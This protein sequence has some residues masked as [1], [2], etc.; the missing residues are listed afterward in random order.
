MQ[1]PPS[2]SPPRSVR[3]SVPALDMTTPFTPNGI[4]LVVPFDFM[5]D[6]EYWRWLPEGVPF[7][8]NRTHKLEDTT[9]T[10]MLAKEVGS[11]KAVV[12]EVKALLDAH[13]ASIGYAC[14]SGS[15]VSGIAG[16]K[17]LQ[18]A[19]LDAGAP[20]AVTSSGA[21]LQALQYL[22]IRRLAIATPYNEELT[23]LLMDYLDEAGFEVVSSGYLDM[24]H[25][26]ARVDYLT[27]QELAK[28]VDTPEAEAIF[29]CCTN[30]HTFDAIEQLETQLGKP[31]LSANQVT[32]WAALR[33]GNLPM[34]DVPQRLFQ[35]S[36]TSTVTPLTDFDTS[37]PAAV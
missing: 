11:D 8:V 7:F 17:H 5:L 15:F 37:A 3:L 30:L 2:T 18:Q 26:I 28:T 35:T 13:P 24:E 27:V 32:V 6:T 4:G 19:M 12:P 1:Q 33:A 20:A 25:A 21:L 36:T 29:F 16:E 9:I 23:Q 31:V 10:S 34:P 22:G 14:S